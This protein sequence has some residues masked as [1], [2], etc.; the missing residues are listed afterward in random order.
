METSDLVKK[1]A[2]WVLLHLAMRL[3]LPSKTENQILVK[4]ID[5]PHDRKWAVQII[6]DM[7]K[8]R[9]QR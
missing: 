3:V 8:S 7:M 6:R 4:D 5:K 9:K 2:F 1:T